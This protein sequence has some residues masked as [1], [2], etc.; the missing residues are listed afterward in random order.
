MR[1]RQRRLDHAA[2]L[3][4][5][6]LG[7][8]DDQNRVLGRQADDGDQ[9]DLKVNVIG[10]AAQQGGQQNAEHAQ[11]HHQNDRQRNRPAFIQR[12]Q[13]QKYRQDG[14]AIQDGR[15]RAGEFFFARLAGPFKAE[16]GWQL[17]RKLFHLG[18]GRARAVA[19]RGTA[20]DAHGRVAV[21]AHGLHGALDPARAG[22]GRQRHLTP[23]RVAGVD[24]QQVFGLHA[25]RRIGLH[26]HTLQAALVGKV[27]HI[28]GA[29]KSGQRTVDR[30]KTHAQRIG[31][32][33]VN[34]DLQLRR[35]FQAIG[36]HLRQHRAFGSHAQQLTAGGQQRVAP[37][38]GTVL[39]A[40]REAAG[41]T[42]LRNRR[43][44]ERKDEGIANARQRA[45]GPAGQR[46]GRLAL[47]LALRPILERDKR[48]RSVL[49][50]PGKAETQHA[51]HAL[52][53]GLLEHK[54]FN[55]LDHRARALQR[56]ARRQLDVDQHGALVFTR[57]KGR[58]QPRVN[59]RHHA[60]DGGVDHQV[61]AGSL[62]QARHQAFITLGRGR[63]AAVEPAEKSALGQVMTGLDRF[64][65]RGT[66]R[67]RER[68]RH[69][70]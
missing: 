22:K 18:H 16:A 2:P 63:K 65:Q 45:K 55:L 36:P 60:D 24:A 52:H 33:A 3:R 6:V 1:R 32:V 47:A 51:D 39:Q 38:T 57:Q 34:V 37:G 64:E 5:Q 49:P 19:R 48:Q 43:R 13:A 40:E 20:A 44:A 35:V 12:R 61:T 53:L 4:L 56:G 21:V 10:I 29:Q 27:V 41:R 70:G 11:R 8:L 59:Q 25:L 50:L 26:H 28:A 67:R 23:L 15:L 69:E 9:A 58:W 46:L 68:Q 62:E 42:E 17:G 66:Q 30:V 7:E 14:K 54:T 31:L